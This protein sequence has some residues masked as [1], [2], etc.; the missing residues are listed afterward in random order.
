MR[1]YLC[2]VSAIAVGGC[3]NTPSFER[4][5]GVT[6][7]SVVDE[8]QC[9]LATAKDAIRQKLSPSVKQSPLESW[10]AVGDLTLQVDEDA[11]L[12]P[13]LSHT[14]LASKTLGIDWGLKLDTQSTRIYTETVTFTIAKLKKDE[15]CANVHR[16]IALN[17]DLGLQEIIEMAFLSRDPTDSG[18][19]IGS[20]GSPQPVIAQHNARPRAFAHAGG[21]G[22]GGGGKSSENAFGTTVEF[23]MTLGVGPTG[24]TWTFTHFKGPGKLFSGDVT[25]TQKLVISFANKLGG[26][27]TR[28]ENTARDL[29]QV[30]TLQ[31]LSSTLRQLPR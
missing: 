5:T 18:V 24:P 2:L 31:G 16:S 9:E 30:M 20:A 22:G 13:A 1:R 14:N 12:A 11:Q 17:G 21:G 23:V 29:N 7:K 6:P 26:P 3:V 19:E 27:T 8:I 4:V 10:I 28:A 15:S 25:H